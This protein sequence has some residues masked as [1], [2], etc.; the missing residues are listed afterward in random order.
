MNKLNKFL[1]LQKNIRIILALILFGSFYNLQ[2]QDRVPYDQG[3]KYIL[4]KVDVTGKINFNAQTV[5]TF[6]GLEKGQNITIPGEEISA[7]I[8]K[9]EKLK[10]FKDIDFYTNKIVGDSIYLELNINEL[11]KLGDVKFVGVKKGKVEALIKDN[12]LTAGKVVNENLITT[13]KNYIENKYKK[14]GFFNTKVN[15]NT[16]KDTTTINEVKMVVTVDKG[17]KVK[18]SNINFTGNEKFTEKRL[19]KAMSNTKIE[20]PIRFWKGSKFIKDKYK[21]DLEKIVDVYKEKGFRDARILSDTVVYNKKKKKLAINIKVEEGHKYYFGNIKFI[22][23][24]VY[25]DSDLRRMLGLN[26]GDVYNGVEL[27]KRIADKSKPDG[28]DIT[29]LYQ[30]NGY[31]FSNINPVEVKTA[32]DS[33]DFEIRIN[34]GPIAYFNKITVVGN[35]KTNDEVI[36]RELR[37]KP[38]QKYSKEELVRTIREIGQLGFFDPE[39]IKP[40]FKN[41]DANAGTVDI[42]YNLVEKGASQIELQGG[43]GGSGFI[44]TLG[45]SFNN[46][47]VRNLFKK[48]AYKPLPMGDGQKMALRLQA[49]GFFTTFSLSFSE[50]W[51]GG[52]KPISFSSS[53]SQSKQYLFTGGASADKSKSFNITS[54]SIGIAKRLTVPDDFFVL[55]HS[56]SF[57]YYDLNNYNTGLFTFGNGSSRNVAYTI[58]LSR[59]NKGINPI[60]P[61]SGSEFS[62]SGK[63]TPPFS[64]FTKLNVAELNAQEEYKLRRTETTPFVANNLGESPA[65]GD[66]VKVSYVAPNGQPIYEVAKTV[67]EASPD[68][69]KVDQKQFNWLEYY[70]IKF[71]ADL[72]T[73]IYGKLVFRTLG[74]FGFL[75]RYNQNIGEVPFER[76]YVGGDGLANFALDGREIVGLR[77]YPNQSLTPTS[78]T[79]APIGATIYNKYSLE[80]RYPITLKAAASIYAISFLEAGGAFSNFKE[81]NPFA[82]KRSAGLGLR[83][84]MPAFGLLGIDFAHGFDSLPG[85]IKAHGWETHFIIG[86]QF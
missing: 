28:D 65:I 60:F 63:F 53:I 69:A 9:L 25:S 17:D 31:L 86:Q 12:N 13:T 68:I 5:V 11:P 82:L 77:G 79:G 48:E 55:S 73:K 51:F 56:L 24:T 54:L 8:K 49:S 27:A 40:D 80:L 47:S 1:V 20:L 75:G 15:I 59:N 43:Y 18:I 32:N 76:F 42:Q 10:L 66:L 33:I 85:E 50:P 14:D 29:N 46:F 23:N 21:E 67:A 45:L 36:Y 58:G 26:K 83:I 6:A 72:Y 62:V 39:A 3:T 64:L 35:D 34:E 22:G 70:K 30:N 38:G 2:A 7:A 44:G 41:V 78:N 16:I 61:T 57:Q 71:K 37:T 52:K 84:F 4:A 74:E 81:Y 19:R